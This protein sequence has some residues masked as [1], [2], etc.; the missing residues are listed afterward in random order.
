MNDGIQSFYSKQ[1]FLSHGGGKALDHLLKNFINWNDKYK[2]YELNKS[3]IRSNL[4]INYTTKW[5]SNIEK[6]TN[7][8]SFSIL[9]QMQR[10]IG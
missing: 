6:L 4:D 1:G 3:N 5:I 7:K 2:I 8:W 9:G 10:M